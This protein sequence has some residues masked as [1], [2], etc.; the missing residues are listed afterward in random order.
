MW[1]CICVK[2]FYR[3]RGILVKHTEGVSEH[4]TEENIYTLDKDDSMRLEKS[5]YIMKN[6][7]NI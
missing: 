2:L 5:K 6:S 4:I 1:F 3:E 7:I